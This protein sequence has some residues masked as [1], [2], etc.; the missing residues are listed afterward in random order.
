MPLS[1][2]EWNDRLF[3]HYF[4]D[5]KRDTEVILY[6][7]EQIIEKIGGVNSSIEDFLNAVKNWG[8]TNSRNFFVN[9]H[10]THLK[11][12]KKNPICFLFRHILRI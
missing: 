8:G 10:L 9:E 11:N 2:L 1:Y 7:D 3:T 5:E 4:N 6:A 12:G